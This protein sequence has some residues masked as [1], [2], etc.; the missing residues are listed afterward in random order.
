[1]SQTFERAIFGAASAL[2]SYY[3]CE[4][5]QSLGRVSVLTC[6]AK[7]FKMTWEL[8]LHT[9]E[10]SLHKIHENEFP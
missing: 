2:I 6:C 7:Y 8:S 9:E 5:E 3:Y 4:C 10:E 1:M